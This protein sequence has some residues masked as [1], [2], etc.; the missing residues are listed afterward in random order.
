MLKLLPELSFD[1]FWFV[2][3][4]SEV[5]YL[6]Q[7]WCFGIYGLV[8][9]DSLVFIAVDD[10]LDLFVPL[11]PGLHYIIDK[12]LSKVGELFWLSCQLGSVSLDYSCCSPVFR[13]Q[14]R[15]RSLLWLPERFVDQGVSLLSLDADLSEVVMV[16]PTESECS[17]GFVGRCFANAVQ[18]QLLDVHLLNPDAVGS[19]REP[20]DEGLSGFL[21]LEQ[22][23]IQV[24]RFPDTKAPGPDGKPMRPLERKVLL[25]GSI[26]A[27][28]LL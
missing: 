1:R 13:V 17:L 25:L 26:L 28:H 10:C 12:L 6:H 27:Q 15:T 2:C 20:W 19:S 16:K 14:D 8:Y 24:P 23:F 3:S 9:G 7:Q 22:D 4:L 21:S 18:F 11:K 5:A